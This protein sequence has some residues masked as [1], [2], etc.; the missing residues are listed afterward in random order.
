MAAHG[1]LVDAQTLQTLNRLQ[2]MTAI[3]EDGDSLSP[4]TAADVEAMIRSEIGS[5]AAETRLLRRRAFRGLQSTVALLGSGCPGR[6]AILLVGDGTPLNPQEG[7]SRALF[8]DDALGA[9][10][11]FEAAPKSLLDVLSYANA[12]GITFYTVNA[13]GL[14]ERSS[15]AVITADVSGNTAFYN[16]DQ[17]RRTM[18]VDDANAIGSLQLAAEKTGGLTILKAT[19]STLKTVA[20]DLGSYYSLGFRPAAADS[21]SERRLEVVVKR[22]G[23][24]VRHRRSHRLLPQRDRLGARALAALVLDPLDNPL[25]VSCAIGRE[26]AAEGTRFRVPVA[27]RVPT[28]NISLAPQQALWKGQL[29]LFLVAKSDSERLSPMKEL[30]I[31]VQLSDQAFR[32]N[33][34]QSFVLRS[35]LLLEAGSSTVAVTV[36]DEGAEVAASVSARVEIDDA[37]HATTITGEGPA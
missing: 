7:I 34:D 18:F 23:V 21:D 24:H 17:L 37:G 12:A 5:A 14:S 2:E 30:V 15:S 16:A 4:M 32:A 28:R 25:G 1:E 13:A 19:P 27:L 26:T 33:L 35:E 9:D 3:A 11:S 20:R 8:P 6:R 22:K 10:G 31:P 36:F 29:R